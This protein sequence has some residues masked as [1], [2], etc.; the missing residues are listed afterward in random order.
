MEQ[1]RHTSITSGESASTS[2]S[3]SAAATAGGSGSSAAGLS[4]GAQCENEPVQRRVS[5]SRARFQIESRFESRLEDSC[6]DPSLSEL[7]TQLDEYRGAHVK[8]LNTID[9][10][11]Q[12]TI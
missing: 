6:D 12:R 1:Q 8:M 9:E 7:K 4:V 11:R 5:K 10:T 2:T 3:A